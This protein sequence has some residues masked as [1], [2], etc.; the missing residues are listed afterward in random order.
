MDNNKTMFKEKIE[1]K[2][3]D[4]RKTI[5]EIPSALVNWGI[6]III[7]IFVTLISIIVFVPYPYGNGESIFAHLFLGMR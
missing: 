5:N 1:L 3:E 6:T 4:V 2:S 7:I